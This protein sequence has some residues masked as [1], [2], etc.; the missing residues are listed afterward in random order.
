MNVINIRPMPTSDSLPL[1]FPHIS[2]LTQ[3]TDLSEEDTGA[4]GTTNTD[5]DD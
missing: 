3:A 1:P 4:L 2:T 5:I